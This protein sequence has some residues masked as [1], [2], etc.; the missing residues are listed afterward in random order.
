MAGSG[1]NGAARHRV[2]ATAREAFLR[3]GFDGMS[4][5]RTARRSGI[6]TSTFY[7]CFKNQ[8]DVFA[9]VYAEWAG[10]ESQALVGL[11]AQPV[12]AAELVDTWVGRLRQNIAFRRS[13]RRLAH[14]EALVR[15]AVAQVRLALL[16]AL[17]AHMGAGAPDDDS[18]A[19]DLL[20]FEQLGTSLAEGELADMGLD[21]SIARQRM[22][23]I[24]KRWRLR[25]DVAVRDRPASF[26]IRS[27]ARQAG[28]AWSS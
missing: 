24:L 3:H 9:A 19:A 17:K 14:E 16:R 8:V 21:W 22:A 27:S 11:M 20:Q 7:R 4:I 10:E 25:G 28:T 23:S 6:S 2:L 26:A 12:P 13:I 5:T 18:L 1:L 15:R